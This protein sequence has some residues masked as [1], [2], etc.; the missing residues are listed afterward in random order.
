MR[1]N[2][3][4]HLGSWMLHFILFPFLFVFKKGKNNSPTIYI[5]YQNISLVP[6]DIN[7]WW[8]GIS[9][10]TFIYEIGAMVVLFHSTQHCPQFHSVFGVHIENKR[11]AWGYMGSIFTLL[12]EEH[13]VLKCL[14][15][16]NNVE[17]DALWATVNQH[18]TSAPCRLI[19]KWSGHSYLLSSS[20]LANHGG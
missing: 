15:V 16:R 7:P 4:G 9:L 3:W 10:Y 14:F 18:P 5:P 2:F 13:L 11:F 12:K 1:T 6:L 17:A 8:K 20:S 19:G